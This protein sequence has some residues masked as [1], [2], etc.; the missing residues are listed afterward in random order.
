MCV[1]SDFDSRMKVL[2]QSEEGYPYEYEMYRLSPQ[3]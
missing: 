1:Q 3:L 2:L